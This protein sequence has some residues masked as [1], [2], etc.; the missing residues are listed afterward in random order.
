MSLLIGPARLLTESVTSDQ[1]DFTK[2]SEENS[3]N[4]DVAQRSDQRVIHTFG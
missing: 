3:L 1:C 2:V 4:R